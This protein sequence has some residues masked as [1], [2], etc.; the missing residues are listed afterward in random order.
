[1]EW[2]ALVVPA[3]KELAVRSLLAKAG[4]EV[5]VPVEMKWKRKGRHVRRA[6]RMVECEYP[7]M[8]RYVFVGF[9]GQPNW[10]VIRNYQFPDGSKMVQGVLGTNGMPRPLTAEAVH[11]LKGLQFAIPTFNPHKGVRAGDTAQF[12][13]GPMRGQIAKVRKIVKRRAIVLVNLF[14]TWREMPV[15]IE[16]LEA[17]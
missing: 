3:Q 1:M 13:Y 16:L 17:A 10:W 7:L 14:N 5:I 6:G 8:P 11:A 15:P 2:Y 4:L 12:I 9:S